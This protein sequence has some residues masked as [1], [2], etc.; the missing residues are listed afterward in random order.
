[1][2]AKTD[3]ENAN[4][5]TLVGYAKEYQIK[6]YSRM[7]KQQLQDELLKAIKKPVPETKST[8]KETP[9][10]FFDR[11]ST[12]LDIDEVRKECEQLI[13]DLGTEKL[14]TKSKFNK[15]QPYSRNFKKL[16]PNPKT[17]H[18]FFDYQ[19]TPNQDA[20][21]RHLFFK[22]TG[23]ADADWEKA[24]TEAKERKS[25][26][27]SKDEVADALN[28]QYKVFNLEKYNSTIKQLLNSKEV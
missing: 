28:E 18:L 14:T 8:E 20:I 10:E 11:V 5:K 3:I 1:M 24:N 26:K 22:F 12:L 19:F 7:P 27:K 25:S 15:L 17:I 9:K 6:G 21:S 2:L 16:T 4:M 13:K 23:L